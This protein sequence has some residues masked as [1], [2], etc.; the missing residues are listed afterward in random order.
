MKLKI[1][2]LLEKKEQSRYWLYKELKLRSDSFLKLINNEPLAIKL[3]TL[4]RLCE[5]LE[6]SPN[7]LIEFD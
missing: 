4:Q 1:D 5:L 3:T 6:C 2:E 7:E